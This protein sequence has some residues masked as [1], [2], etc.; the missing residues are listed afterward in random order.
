MHQRERDGVEDVK[1][2]EMGKG[3]QEKEMERRRSEARGRKRR[4]GWE[5]RKRG[6][7]KE[8]GRGQVGGEGEDEMRVRWRGERETRGREK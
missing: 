4:V 8:R 1:R 6:G 2:G 3:L 5:E 7:L